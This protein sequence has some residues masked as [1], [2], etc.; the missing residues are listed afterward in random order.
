MD[1]YSRK[2]LSKYLTDMIDFNKHDINIFINDMWQKYAGD[3][4]RLFKITRWLELHF[5]PMGKRSQPSQG[6]FFV[7]I[8]LQREP[9][10][11]TYYHIF[12]AGCCWI[13]ISHPIPLDGW[14]RQVI[15][16]TISSQL[17]VAG[18]L[19]PIPKNMSSD[20][21]ACLYIISYLKK[22]KIYMK[23]Y[24]KYIFNSEPCLFFNHTE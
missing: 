7:W 5:W 3:I 16:T 10:T 8:T 6:D 17:A 9:C 23:L 12:I 21:T 22:Y 1:Y 14:L 15:L 4:G 20:V 24:I 19:F 11:Y 13:F 2:S 18:F